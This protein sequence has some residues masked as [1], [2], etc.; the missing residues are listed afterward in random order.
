MNWMSGKT[1][2]IL[3]A[4]IEFDRAGNFLALFPLTSSDSDSA[5]VEDA[6]N[7]LAIRNLETDEPTIT[8]E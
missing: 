2:N 3:S 4:L 1:G 8:T 6:F 7:K 5:I